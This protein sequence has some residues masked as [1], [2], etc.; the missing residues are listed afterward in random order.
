METRK[1]DNFHKILPYFEHVGEDDFLFVQ[2]IQR[3]KEIPELGCNN[4]LVKSYTV[5]T[6]EELIKYESEIKTI[7]DALNA[8][9]YI[10]LSPRN[11]LSVQSGMLSSIAEYYKSKT[12]KHIP[13]LFNTVCGKETGTRKLWLFDLD[14]K[15]Y[16]YP[17]ELS[18]C[19]KEIEKKELR[20]ILVDT[21][22][23]KNGWHFITNPFNVGAYTIA[24]EA[25]LHKNNP[26]IL[27][28]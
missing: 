22:P 11:F 17:Y 16:Q 7:T 23:T 15:E 13:K 8:R 12:Y 10:H 4:R 24:P 27:Y 18:E 9:A 5:K 25:E 6:Y 21:F 1:V 20:Q 3:K 28:V 26:T 2:I 19:F 14:H